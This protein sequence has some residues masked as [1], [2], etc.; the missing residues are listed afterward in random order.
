LKKTPSLIR[1][2]PPTWL[3]LLW[4]VPFY[5]LLSYCPLGFEA[6]L[7]L[8]VVGGG[9]AFLF[10][11]P[12]PK[13]PP[14]PPAFPLP[15]GAWALLLLLA[16]ALRLLWIG[17]FPSWPLYDEMINSYYAMRLDQHWNWHLFFFWSNLPP[18]LIWMLAALFKVIPSTLAAIR[19]LPLLLTLAIVPLAYAAIRRFCPPTT[20]FL[21]LAVVSTGFGFLYFGRLCHQGL[22]LLFWEF[23]T[24]WTLGGVL[25]A[26]TPKSQAGWLAACGLAIGSGFYTYFSWPTVALT[27]SLPLLWRI[28]RQPHKIRQGLCF[29][30]PLLAALTPLLAAL[31][32]KEFGSYYKF[33]FAFSRGSFTPLD[34]LALIGQVLSGFLFGYPLPEFYYGPVWGGFFNPLSGSFLVIGLLALIWKDKTPRRL[35]ILGAAAV[36]L[37]PAFLSG[38]P[39]S[40]M[41]V[42]QALPLMAFVAVQGLERLLAA[43]PPLRRAPLLL[44]AL[45]LSTGLD[46]IH[47][48]KTKTYLQGYFNFQKTEEFPL[49]FPY[50][51]EQ[52]RQMGPG[53]LL[54]D[55]HM[56][57]FH[58]YSLRVACFPFNTADN[59]RLAQTPPAWMAVLCNVHYQPF[60][61]KRFPKGRWI[62]LTR[63]PAYAKTNFDGG[64][65]LGIIPLATAEDR[66]TAA[67]WKTLNDR[68]DSLLPVYVGLRPEAARHMAQQAFA[69]LAPEVGPDPFLQSCYWD[70]N[71]TLHNW[72][73]MY[74]KR[75]SENYQASFESMFNAVHRGYP[76]AYFYNELSFFYLRAGDYARAEACCE[77][78][79]Q[80]PLNL[81]PAAQN[82][83]AIREAQRQKSRPVGQFNK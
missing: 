4:L 79:L 32:Q 56:S 58:D 76:T 1:K 6:K 20:S 8:F 44:A 5:S 53:L 22:L 55:L 33:L 47:L 3:L 62:W 77:K 39:L 57:V 64:L 34:H 69:Q 81:T 66:Q 54:P 63:D 12:E 28:A 18:L 65:L 75:T 27:A 50:L 40:E 49:A 52:A 30:I 10:W 48:E 15:A 46:L 23:L 11:R 36:L 13:D 72:E 14:K 82:L 61:A 41:R 60:L 38:P 37:A 74:G 59:P 51:R 29:L 35:W 19:L 80:A 45:T 25:Q 9:C 70:M 78:A 2:A 21:Y 17:Q 73:N 31:F 68:I 24:L 7:W 83:Q 26:K 43:V 67:E 42:I 16:L 71:Y